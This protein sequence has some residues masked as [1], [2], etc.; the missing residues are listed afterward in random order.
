LLAMKENLRPNPPS[1][2]VATQSAGGAPGTWHIRLTWD[3]NSETDMSYYK[4]YRLRQGVDTTYSV[5]SP[6]NQPASPL[7]DDPLDYAANVNVLYKVSAVD[8]GGNEG[9]TSLVAWVSTGDPGPSAPTGLVA[10]SGDKVVNLTWFVPTTARSGILGY[11]VD[12]RLLV[13]SHD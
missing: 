2:L 4:V 5:I 10:V 12:R 13:G 3:A 11:E 9:A 6:Q 7:F 8:N 1:N